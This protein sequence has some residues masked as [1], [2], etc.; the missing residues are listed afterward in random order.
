MKRHARTAKE[1]L[2]LFALFGMQIA[3]VSS[4]F[5]AGELSRTA[6]LVAAGVARS[7]N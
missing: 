4:A 5:C 6:A 2:A 1:L 7:T 3:N